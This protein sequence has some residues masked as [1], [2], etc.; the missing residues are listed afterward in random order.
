MSHENYFI[1][2]I[3]YLHEMY[4]YFSN[5]FQPFL[6]NTHVFWRIMIYQVEIVI[7]N[8]PKYK[9]TR[10][11]PPLTLGNDN[12]CS[13]SQRVV[14]GTTYQGVYKRRT[15]VASEIN[16]CALSPCFFINIFKYIYVIELPI[17]D[18]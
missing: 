17:D 3:N 11:H 8:K 7:K 16:E 15:F 14:M 9:M 1:H 10:E 18:C 2:V 5:N 4:I 13:I 12:T 6:L